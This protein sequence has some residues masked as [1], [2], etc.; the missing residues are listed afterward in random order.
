MSARR[1]DLTADEKLV[2]RIVKDQQPLKRDRL[3][4]LSPLGREDTVEAMKALYI[5][6]RTYLD[7]SL[8]FVS[9]KRQ[10]TSRESAWIQIVK[11]LFDNYGIMTAESL[12]M[13]LG[14]EIPM[15][16]IRRAL[17]TLEDEK[18]LVKGFLLKGSGALHWASVQAYSKLGKIGFSQHVVLSPED[19]LTQ[20]LRA[21]CRDLLPETGRHAIFQGTKVIGSFEG[22]IKAGRFEVSDLQGDPTCPEIVGAYARSL[23]LALTDRDEGRVSDWEI[24][25][26]YQRTH[27]GL[28]DE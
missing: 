12:G 2:L 10:K 23:G 7:S 28:G 13:L 18:L 4:D 24:M 8:S 19:N 11:R 27:P 15:R 9:T 20:F 14:H 3:L 22:K 5:S 25:D 6:S 17:R 16:E 1:S 26:F 21:S